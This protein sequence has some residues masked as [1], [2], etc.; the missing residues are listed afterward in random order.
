[1]SI[2]SAVDLRSSW[3][4]YAAVTGVLGLLVFVAGLV[5]LVRGE[6]TV[7]GVDLGI[8]DQPTWVVLLLTVGAAALL[9]GAALRL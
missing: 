7:L 8:G 2:D 1:M 5:T 4:L 3:S 9:A 6:S